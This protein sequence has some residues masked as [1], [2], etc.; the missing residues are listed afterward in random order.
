[1]Y[2]SN[3]LKKEKEPGV[4]RRFI[5]QLADPLIYILLVAA[6]ISFLLHE[7][8]DACIILVVVLLNG[9]IGMIQEGK[10]RRALEGLEKLTAPHAYVIR[11]EG[12]RE[13]PA[14]QLVP[15]DLVRLEA[16]SF[17]P[18]DGKLIE[19][20]NLKCDEASLSGESVPVEKP[21]GEHLWMSTY[22][23]YGRGVAEITATGMDT[24]I[25]RIA[26]MVSKAPMQS[27]PLQKR[28]KDLG[29]V[30]SVLAVGLCVIMFILA[31]LQHRPVGEMLLT[32]ISLAVAAVPEG[33]PAV[34]TIVLALSVSR[35]VKVH[36]IVRRLPS[37]ET[38]GCVSVVCS[39][40]TGTLT[41][42]K[43]EVQQIWSGGKVYRP[44]ALKGSRDRMLVE[45]L[46]LCNDA[47]ISGAKRVG[48]P[49]ELALL[50]LG[51]LL[52]VYQHTLL[53]KCVR[54][55]EIPFSSE[56]KRMVTLHRVDGRSVEYMKGALSSILPVCDRFYNGRE[57]VPMTTELRNRIRTAADHMSAQALRVLAAASKETKHL[58]ERGMTF[59]GFVGMLDP[60]R[61]EAAKAIR[62]FQSA[63]VRTVMITGDDAHTAAAIGNQLGLGVS[64]RAACITGEELDAM[65]DTALQKR[66]K[67]ARIFARVSPEHKCRIVQAFQNNGE[68][69]AMTGDGTNDAPA[70][71]LADIGIAMGKGGTDV[72]RSAAD[73]VLTDD[74]FATIREA[75]SEGRS[76]YENIKKAVVFL[77]SSNFG[78]IITMLSA[79]AAGVAA[80]LK[81]SHILWINLITDSLPALALGCD[82]N[83]REALLRR[84][85]RAPGESLFAHGALALTCFY[86]LLIA[87]ISLAAFLYLPVL[88][89]RGS[90]CAVNLASLRYILSQKEVL[91]HAQT[92]AFTVLW[93][94]QLFHAI[95]MRDVHQ[96][97]FRMNLLDNPLMLL[98]LGVGIGLQLLVTE[99]PFLVSAFQTAKLTLSEWG[100]L[101]GLSMVP[102][103]AHEGI[104]LWGVLKNGG[105]RNGDALG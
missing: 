89:I 13:I 37:V 25:G 57:V 48:D 76:I 101:L 28:L 41:Q 96:S 71:R 105:R 23:T 60:V 43:M 10:A 50:D 42:N 93:L 44:E 47:K 99:V 30:L 103:L 27:T 62:E 34:V 11:A 61:P 75:I 74:N 98:S 58:T 67:S 90:G 40:K 22:V 64:E 45:A 32:A 59:L 46:V 9:L 16:G 84:P 102:I 1:M 81:P 78:E 91:L 51:N 24:R 33:L 20:I 83:D 82:E 100:V 15:G 95:G 39:D 55:G 54:V 88:L 69:V 80:P 92:Y 2:G 21:T 65:S 31:I 63:G 56:T 35:L 12:E 85:P 73:F 6:I 29:T 36:T 14:E 18:A 49:T 52:G 87:G 8:S 94:S 19:S 53:L 66:V 104:V 5:D 77:L 4:I 26:G 7:V 86:G 3:A 38:L 79:V 17:V 72:A 70:L 68:I 97:V